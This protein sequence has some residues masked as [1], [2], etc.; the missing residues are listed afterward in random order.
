M[1]TDQ[2]SSVPGGRSV[3]VSESRRRVAAFFDMDKTIIAE[4]S[5]SVYMKHL[6]RQGEVGAF[7]LA[8]GLVAYLRYKLGMLDIEAS[9][10]S[11]VIGLKGRTASDLIEEG[12]TLCAQEI[13]PLIYPAAAATIRDHQKKGDLVCI[14]SGSLGFVVE[15]VAAHLGVQHMIHSQLEMEDGRVTGEL[16]QPL[17]FEEGKLYW[18]RDFIRHHQIDLARSWFYSDSVTDRPLLEQV[19][20]PVAVNPDPRLYVLAL[21]RGWPVRLFELDEAPGAEDTEEMGAD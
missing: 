8:I 11:L 12:R 13:V 7:D 1:V 4:N 19:G 20:H 6:F 15:P 14:V 3:A 16:V 21:R 18:L 9:T 5:G 17:C 2:D 10:R